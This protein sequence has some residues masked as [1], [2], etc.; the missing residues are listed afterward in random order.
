MFKRLFL[1]SPLRL[2]AAFWAAAVILFFFDFYGA[3]ATAPNKL[4]VAVYVALQILLLLWIDRVKVPRLRPTMTSQRNA[5]IYFFV[6]LVVSM[7]VLPLNI[8][9]YAGAQISEFG[10]ML[11]D[12]AAAYERMRLAVSVDRSERFDF[13]LLKLS[14]S[15]LTVA[16]V[17]LAIILRQRRL[18]SLPIFFLALSLPFIQSVFRGTDKETGDILVF[19]IAGLFIRPLAENVTTQAASAKR[20]LRLFSPRMLPPL[21]GG[22]V[23]LYF[24]AT[25]KGERLS[26][27]TYFCFH[28]SDACMTMPNPADDA[29]AFLLANAYLYVTHSFYG[30]GTALNADPVM[31]PLV[32]HSAVLMYLFGASLG[33]ETTILSQ[34]D[35]LGWASTASW[36]TGF[37]QLANDY[38]FLGTFVQIALHAFAL[39][40]FHRTYQQNGDFISG[41]LFILNFFVLF[42]MVANLQLQQVGDNYFGYMFLNLFVVLGMLRKVPQAP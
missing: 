25:R 10:A 20:R 34:L 39:K 16:L 29:L 9:N 1:K 13:L 26:E 28:N 8:Y 33:C 2:I 41:V 4:F 14:I 6:A 7:V 31:C 3:Y 22:A 19:L 35:N 27:M 15:W 23:F 32:G 18:I 21:L 24:M 40:V 12:P 38:G 17:P 30:L 36:S 11:A 5:R 37:V 42:Y